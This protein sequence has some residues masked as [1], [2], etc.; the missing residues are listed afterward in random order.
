[1]DNE[2]ELGVLVRDD[3]T[4]GAQFRCAHHVNTDDATIA[5]SAD[6]GNELIRGRCGL[7]NDPVHFYAP[8]MSN[9]EQGHQELMTRDIKE[10][11]AYS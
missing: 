9:A 1:M 4:L 5:F 6:M 3:L 2:L 8:E 7:C 11:L 10:A